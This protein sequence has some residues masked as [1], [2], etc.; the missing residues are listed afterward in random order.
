MSRRAFKAEEPV[1][2]TGPEG[3]F[4][5]PNDESDDMGLLIE[6]NIIVIGSVYI[7]KRLLSYERCL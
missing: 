4:F 3:E 1:R 7:L 2:L 6:A 5:K